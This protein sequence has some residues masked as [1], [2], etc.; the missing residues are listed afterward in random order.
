M[1]RTLGGAGILVCEL[2]AS[3]TTSTTTKKKACDGTFETLSL[4]IILHAV[5]NCMEDISGKQHGA[6]L[7]L[8][9][10]VPG[11]FYRWCC[12]LSS[13]NF[14]TLLEVSFCAINHALVMLTFEIGRILRHRAA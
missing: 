11:Y 7:S 5:H 14:S 1:W 10:R 9:Y 13:V 8:A 12:C 2:A 4:N 6:N 3:T